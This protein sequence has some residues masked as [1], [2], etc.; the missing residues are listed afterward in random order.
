MI[1]RS[2]IYSFIFLAV[3]IAALAEN[4]YKSY[5]RKSAYQDLLELS[6]AKNQFT[7]TLY[8]DSDTLTIFFEKS[9]VRSA[10]DGISIKGQPFLTDRGF[11]LPS[12]TIPVSAIERIETKD[13]KNGFQVYFKRKAESE[14]ARTFRFKKNR[15]TTR[16]NVNIE[17]GEFIR[18]L[19]IAFWGDIEIYGEV[20]EDVVAIFGDITIGD[21]AVV[22]GDVS[23]LN[24]S[25]SA[26]KHATI[27]GEIRASHSNNKYTYKSLSRWYRRD[28]YFTEYGHFYYNRVD[29]VAPYLGF[30]FIDEDSLLPEITVYGGYGFSS[31]DWRYNISVDQSFLLS[32]PLT[33]GGSIYRRLASDDDH[34]ISEAQNTV[35]ALIAT[36]DYKDYYEAEGGYLF[37]RFRPFADISLESGLLF[38]KYRMVEGHPELWS[39]FGGSKR[40]PVNFSSLPEDQRVSGLQEIDSK[41]I[42]AVIGRI[43][44]NAP[45]IK[46]DWRRSSWKI[47]A[48]YEWLPSK[49]NDDFDFSRLRL[50]IGR[51][52]RID[53]FNRVYSSLMFGTSDG[54]LPIHRKFYMGGYGTLLGYRHKEFFG[55]KFWVIDAEYGIN[56]PHTD[57]TAWLFYNVGQMAQRYISFG[58]TEVKHS[59]GIGISF[60]DSIRFNVARR[61]D[62][63]EASFEINVNFGFND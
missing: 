45:D 53:R 10:E 57:A 1:S 23:A 31:E 51:M 48:E 47:W 16:D 46:N 44:F 33:L 43:K 36:E 25:I 13:D 63:S 11:V 22:R 41:K 7:A 9:D 26:S 20:N 14:S 34:L 6:V 37:V 3:A 24:G 58:D 17:A 29:G 60:D 28:K 59:L 38:E 40:F 32:K 4:K 61:L 35:F 55:D 52:Q 54:Y 39:L 19:V 15:I 18:G 62:S 5:S 21:Q 30:K 50:K 27:Y 2:L 12:E 42:T 49:W 8:G 56:L